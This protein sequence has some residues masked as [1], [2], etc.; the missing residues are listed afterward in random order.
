MVE[1][2]FSLKKTKTSSSSCKNDSL[3]HP[4]LANKNVKQ[5]L[6]EMSIQS[7]SWCILQSSQEVEAT[8]MSTSRWLDKQNVV[9]TYWKTLS[10]VKESCHMLQHWLTLEHDTKWNKAVTKRQKPWVHLFKVRGQFTQIESST[11]VSKGWGRGSLHVFNV[12]GISSF[13]F[14]WCGP[15][16]KIFIEFVTIWFLFLCFRFLATGHMGP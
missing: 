16:C 15:F 4:K 14:F 11:V 1:K 9:H 10:L 5:S 2:W 8:Q 3:L 13:F 6:K 7:C 12:C